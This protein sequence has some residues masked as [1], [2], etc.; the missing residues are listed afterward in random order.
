MAMRFPPLRHALRQPLASPRATQRRWAR[1]QDVRFLVTH[2]T[3]ERV[4]AKYRD[5]LES[6]AREKGL[7]DLNEL[8]EQYKDRIEELRKQAIV[9]GATGPLT[10]PPEQ[11]Q[12]Q[13]QQRQTQNTPPPSRPDGPQTS[14]PPPP[15]P[16][17][18]PPRAGAGSPTAPPPGV[19]TLNS[20]LAVDK[21]KEN[22]REEIEALWR[23][24]HA[25]NPQGIH[26][27]VPA[28]TFSNL[29]S[30][31]KQH[32]SFVLPI[33]REMP[34][35]PDAAPDAQGQMQQ[36]VELHYLQFAHPHDHTTTLMFTTLA[37][38][39]LRGEF[40]SPHTT[41][42]FHQELAGS[43]N[44][45][46]GQGL[47]VEKRG[48]SLDDARWLIMCMQ[49]FYVQTDEGKGRS[50]L[51]DMFTRGDSAFKVERLIDEAEKVL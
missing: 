7:R 30:S 32:P 5:K 22:T 16:P 29:L 18:P 27:A 46:L 36:A 25:N 11:Q 14:S 42:T 17:P 4:L 9:P 34:A 37:E 50:E 12:Q 3:Q 41:V 47:V 1:V 6:K 2:D 43:H 19:Q 45:V 49:K 38:F 40:A 31:A 28:S 33:P 20:F 48:V 24:R 13:Q 23:M 26:F 44:L 15:P 35:D 10:P 51:L 21:I 39:K 8:K